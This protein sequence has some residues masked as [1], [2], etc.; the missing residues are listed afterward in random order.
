MLF[1]P[2]G[3]RA[4]TWNWSVTSNNESAQGTFTT[5]GATAQAGVTEAI[6]G[7]TGTYTR[8]NTGVDDGTYTIT[9]LSQYAGASNTFQWD[10][11]NPS[12]L[13]SDG[14][15]ISFTFSEVNQNV[16][17]FFSNESFGG[18]NTIIS[19]FGP[20]TAGTITSSTLAPQDVPG[21]LPLLGAGAAFGWSR[22]LRRRLKAGSVPTASSFKTVSLPSVLPP[23]A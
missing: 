3:A 2:N 13:I 5:A 18:V 20:G 8:F 21:P 7:V 16:N 19:Q 9:G 15:G 12:P 10:G 17:I 1:A 22:R 4:L 6:T 14:G 23:L 11:T